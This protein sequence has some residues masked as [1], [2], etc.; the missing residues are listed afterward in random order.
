MTVID[1]PEDVSLE[2]L[3]RLPVHE[4]GGLRSVSKSWNELL[5]SRSFSEARRESGMCDEVLFVLPEEPVG[6]PFHAYSAELNR[7][8]TLPP[9]PGRSPTER[10]TGFSCVGAG[11]KL[12]VLGGTV[13]VGCGPEANDDSGMDEAVTPAVRIFDPL[14]WKWSWASPMVTAR[15][16]FAC[17]AIEGNRILVSG[18]QGTASFLKSA[19]IYDIR[20][21]TWRPVSSMKEERSSHRGEV[22]DGKFWA[23]GGEVVRH[24]AWHFPGQTQT[25]SIEIYDLELDTW[26]F[27][28][29]L[30]IDAN[31]VPSPTAVLNNKLYTVQNGAVM[32]LEKEKRTW[33]RFGP[34][35]GA[36]SGNRPFGRFGFGCAAL[37]GKLLLVGGS[38][39]L[40]LQPNRC[41]RQSLSRMDA[42]VPDEGALKG[43]AAPDDC[44]NDPQ[45]TD[46]FGFQK[47]RESIL[48]WQQ[49]AHMGT[50]KGSILGI[51][52]VRV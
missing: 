38:Q 47:A 16:W 15:S 31:K 8:R 29:S 36:A 49:L 19:E 34:A 48:M 20:S 42:C 5:T 21:D 50:G 4:Q 17:S 23:I 28:S 37:G 40:W 10:L 30:W 43:T 32:V 46:R 14:T 12:Y 6:G 39:E 18:G 51:A 52:V 1:L 7:W 2:I 22:I 44:T 24:D 9:M 3:V 33:R 35:P 13:H 11:G 41:S 45:F 27:E 25:A 26:H